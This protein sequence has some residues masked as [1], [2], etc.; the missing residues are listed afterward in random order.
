MIDHDRLFKELISTFFLEFL[1]LFAPD[2]CAYVD[3]A[4]LVFLDKEVFTDVTSGE[5]HEADL[6][7]R[8]K[9]RGQEAFFLV[10]V[11]TQAQPQTEYGRRMFRYFARFH[12]KYHLPVYPIAVFTYDRP[13]RKQPTVY[14]VAFPH[15][16][17]MQ[18]RY[19]VVQLNRL[20][21]R[22][23]LRHENPAANALMAK[24]QMT[25]EDRP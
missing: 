16:V 20:R 24:M 19:D 25:P 10:H 5:S 18:F 6:V 11:E 8:A 12:E 2:V 3:E 17:V 15:R 4:S 7:A 21:W 13:R 14:Q 1:E 23:Y 9:F 22:D